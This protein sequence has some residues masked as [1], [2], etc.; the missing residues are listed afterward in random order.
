M[1]Y[2]LLILFKSLY[3]YKS[4]NTEKFKQLF[5]SSVF[6]I[7]ESLSFNFN[8]LK[9]KKLF[10]IFNL[11]IQPILSIAQSNKTW[12]KSN[13]TSFQD[14]L[15]FI[16]NSNYNSYADSLLKKE[17][18]KANRFKLKDTLLKA[19]QL[20]LSTEIE[21]AVQIFKEISNL[22]YKA[23]WNK[24]ER[25][26]I[27]YAL[28]RTAQIEED[29][30]KQKAL[31]ILASDFFAFEINKESYSDYNLF[32]PPL[33]SQ[34]ELIQKKKT[35]LFVDWNKIFPDHEIILL[36]GQKLNK[37]KSLELNQA[38]YKITALSSS[39]KVWS[40]VISLSELLRQTIK[41]ASLTKGTCKKVALAEHIQTENIEIV[42]I[43][44]CPSLTPFKIKDELMNYQLEKKTK[45]SKQIKDNWPTWAVI[46]V[47]AIILSLAIS[48]GGSKDEKAEE[49]FVY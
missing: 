40:Q 37:N 10:I 9:I 8:F 34:L 33:M 12:I 19:Q 17:R 21:R 7:I 24:E 18:D 35:K 16:E 28:L 45:N 5:I 42:P 11:L 2:Y 29:K 23:N 26:I 1:F 13:Y 41:T 25:R 15:V 43:L 14:F 32:P 39:H 4:K 20:Y 38:I 47:G 22:A 46:G 49:D 44:N 27:M 31:L 6:F 36:N 48:L 30:E 3:F